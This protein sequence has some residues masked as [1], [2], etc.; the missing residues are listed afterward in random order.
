MGA[1]ARVNSP[2]ACTGVA[3]GSGRAVGDGAIV[4]SGRAIVGSVVGEALAGGTD[5]GTVVG[6]D[7]VPGAMH[8]AA[9]RLTIKIHIACLRMVIPSALFGLLSHNGLSGAAR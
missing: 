2:P 9:S 4:A 8:A 1:S 3:A 7:G 5:D 6:A